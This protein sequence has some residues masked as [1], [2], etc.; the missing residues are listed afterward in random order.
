MIGDPPNIM[1][2]SAAKLHFLDFVLNVAPAAVLV[3]FV[4]MGFLSIVYRRV[5]FKKCQQRWSKGSIQEGPSSTKTLL[6]VHNADS[7]VLVLFPPKGARAGEF[8]GGP[9]RRVLL[10][11]FPEQGG[12]RRSSQRD[13]MGRHFL[14]HRSF[15]RRRRAG[16]NGCSGKISA[17]VSRMSGGKMERALI[18]V[19]GIS[20]ISSAFVDNIPFTAT[21]IPVI[22]KLAILSPEN[23]S[24][25]RP[26]WWALSLGACLGKR[27]PGWSVCEHHRNLIGCGQKTHH[28]LG[29]FQSGFSCTLNQSSGFW[30]VPFVQI[31]R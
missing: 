13:R 7:F 10:S 16:R 11:C 4:V 2:A 21:M 22:K 18:S 30:G 25:L 6:S 27:Y 31:L 28:V 8:R 1:I 14:L 17:L 23:F 20:G 3:F 15:S 24:D 29:L 26:L 12:N 5:I 9:V 19:L